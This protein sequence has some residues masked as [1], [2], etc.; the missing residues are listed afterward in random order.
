MLSCW[1][2]IILQEAVLWPQVSP[3]AGSPADAAGPA[4]QLIPFAPVPQGQAL[5]STGQDQKS[6][7]VV[8]QSIMLFNI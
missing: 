5:Q 3:S 6:P 1:V 8:S 2:Y 7:L 4:L